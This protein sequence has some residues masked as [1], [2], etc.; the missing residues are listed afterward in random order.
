MAESLIP[1]SMP[2]FVSDWNTLTIPTGTTKILSADPNRL[3]LLLSLP[4]AASGS[5]IRVGGSGT[6]SLTFGPSQG[7]LYEITWT[8]HGPLVQAEVWFTVGFTSADISYAWT[9]RQ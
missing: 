2:V 7:T 9:R 4:T 5:L 3:A 8:K 1:S 6:K